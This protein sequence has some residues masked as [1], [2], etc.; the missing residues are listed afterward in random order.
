M[1]IHVRVLGSACLELDGAR[2]RLSP[3]A[4]KLLLRLVAAEGKTVPAG[5]L[6]RELWAAPPDLRITRG[7]R[8]EVQKRVHELRRAMA[9]G[10]PGEGAGPLRTEQSLTGRE[11]VSAYRLVLDQGQLDRL[12]FERLVNQATHSAPGHA[13]ALL[14][15]ALRL[16]RGTPFEEVAGSAF[17]QPLV[18]RLTDLH[19]MA[20]RELLRAHSTLGQLHLALPL[21]ESLA[22]ETPDDPEAVRTLRE[23][24]ENLRARHGDDVLR[25]PITPLRTTVVVKH[26]D[27]FD[28]EDANL[29][30][31]FGDTFDTS[32]DEDVVISRD[33]VQGQLLR[34]LYADRRGDLDRQLRKALRGVPP[35]GTETARDKPRGKRVRYPLGTVVPLPLPGRRVFATVYC[36][37]GNDLVTRGTKDQLRASLDRLWDAVIV[38]GLYKPVAVPLLGSRL[39]RIDGIDDEESLRMIVE[40]FLRASR[41]TPVAPELRVM[42]HT[43]SLERIRIW[44]VSRFLDSLDGSVRTGDE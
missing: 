37:Q 33:S 43:P 27:L 10:H 5:A 30:V 21:A 36:R 19:S 42:V 44:D 34:R 41:R 1:R 31:G 14:G 40:S 29:V 24:R 35:A 17:A 7:H 6:Y 2:V 20:R 23:L 26:G 8:T 38:H 39:A 16:W 22:R 18:R 15:E 12:E 9:D 25:H 4:V 13:V 3:Q 28:Q 32:T 11:P